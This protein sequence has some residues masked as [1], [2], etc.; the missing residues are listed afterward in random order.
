MI[1]ETAEQW[2]RDNESP[3]KAAA[4]LSAG[5]GEEDRLGAEA[6]ALTSRLAPQEEGREASNKGEREGGKAEKSGQGRADADN[7]GRP[8][9]QPPR[10]RA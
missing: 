5:V 7:G 9:K 10:T 6:E 8:K 3:R 4:V 1:Q 2:E